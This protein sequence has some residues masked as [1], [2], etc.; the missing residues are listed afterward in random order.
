MRQ[1]L[2]DHHLDSTGPSEALHRWLLAHPGLHTVAVY[3]PLP[4]EVELSA[5]VAEHPSIRWVYPK[6]SGL[7]LTFHSGNDHRPGAFGILEPHDDSPEVPLQEIDAIVCPGLAFDMNGGRLGRGR[8]L[9]DRLLAQ[10]RPDTIK[11][12]VCF[13]EQLVVDTFSEA[14]DMRMDEVLF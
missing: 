5:A 7:H 12:G 4:G 10:A 1:I 9:Y 13:P 8:G 3:S 2:R 14:H 6:V 11:L